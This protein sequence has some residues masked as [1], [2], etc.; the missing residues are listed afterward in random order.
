MNEF[1]QRN[2]S[3]SKEQLAFAR[4]IIEQMKVKLVELQKVKE[5]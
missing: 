1:K 4:E 5:N 2:Y 3:F